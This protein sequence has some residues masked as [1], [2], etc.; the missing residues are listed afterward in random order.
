MP[1]TKSDNKLVKPVHNKDYTT[2]PYPD[3]I[4][5]KL[6]EKHKDDKWWICYENSNHDNK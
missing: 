3:D 2:R 5:E 4:L 1:K 6:R